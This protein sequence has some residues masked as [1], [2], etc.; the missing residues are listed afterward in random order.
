MHLRHNNLRFQRSVS[1]P[2]S[3]REELIIR[4]TD[5]LSEMAVRLSVESHE[6]SASLEVSPE[7][8]QVCSPPELSAA[9]YD[10]IIAEM[11]QPRSMESQQQHLNPSNEMPEQSIARLN[12][13]SLFG[14][15]LSA[16][17]YEPLD[18]DVESEELYS[19]SFERSR[20]SQNSSRLNW[21]ASDS[22]G[23]SSSDR[24]DSASGKENLRTHT[25]RR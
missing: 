7:S 13:A 18:S 14:I 8:I 1:L 9:A 23:V 20:N 4:Q 12:S 15:P 10:E 17:L 22:S 3:K 16:N 25:R 21:F 24:S 6:T 2:E 19:A 11:S 5:G